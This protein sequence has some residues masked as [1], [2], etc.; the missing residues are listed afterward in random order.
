MVLDINQSKEY[1][2]LREKVRERLFC[3]M[4]PQQFKVVERGSGPVLCLA[5]AGSGKTTAMVNRILHLYLFGPQF[6]PQPTI[7]N[8]IIPEDVD[9]LREWVEE[10][11]QGKV[12]ELSPRVLELVRSE[13]IPARSILAI[14]FTNKAA[15][16]MQTRL[17]NLLGGTL[18]DMWV[19]TFHAACV[20]ILHR[21]I[22]ALDYTG[23]FSI[24]DAQDQEQ[25]IK[26]VLK[27]M[28]LDDKKFPP[29]AIRT[30]ISKF[31]SELKGVR[32]AA[33]GARDY[34]EEKGAQAYELYQKQLKENN[35][36]DFDDLIMLT[37]KLFRTNP[38]I[39]QKYQERF[40]YIMVDEYQDTN[41][42]QYVLVNLL[43]DAHHNLCVVGDDDQS[44]YGF[45]QADIRNILDFERDNPD[46][47]VIKLE[48]NYRSTC[49]ILA[50]ANE[51]IKNNMGRKDKTLW[52]QNPE[53]ELIV[54]YRAY[55]E[56]DE[57]RFVADR[58]RELV[59]KGST[60]QECAVLMRTNAQSRALE[61]EFMRSG[62]PYRIYGGLRFYDRK[63]IK[64][65]LAY[66]KL[67]VNPSD[68][69]S[70]RRIINVPR[71]GIGEATL[72]KIAEYSSQNGLS[73][74]GGLGYHKELSVVGKAGRGIESFVQL[75]DKLKEDV[76]DPTVTKITERI[77]METGYWDELN[78]ENTM[79][80]QSRMENLKEFMTVTQ[81]YDN[82]AEGPSLSDFLS[83]IS[84]VTD[85]D[86]FEDET[87]AVVVMTMHMA[88]GLEFNNV[89]LVG[90][91]E[92]IFPHS[93]SLLDEKEVEEERRLCYVALTRARERLF[94]I[95]AKERTIYGRR[96]NNKSS[97]F[98]GE[99]PAEFREEYQTGSD[100]F[101][102]TPADYQATGRR[103]TGYI[104]SN[105]DYTIGDKVEHKKWG[106]GVVVSIRGQG[107]E[108]ELKI[109]FPSEGIKTL[110]AR[111]APLQKIK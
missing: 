92:G 41:H 63:E 104:P 33:K 72:L 11:S 106:Q 44:I 25:I 111:Y 98:M 83:R 35:A 39:L 50:A 12:E 26:R 10:N 108:A 66:L 79:E 107:G 62:I 57:A 28:D 76:K 80:S 89:F 1:W 17:A 48:Q 54:Q 13:G 16:E 9:L 36:L 38:E 58:V 32:E 2:S 5:G 91:E 8:D 46:S 77:I 55:T 96:S 74:Y 7:P 97:R 99:I 95:N 88:K 29:R 52:T 110:L 15:Q 87:K 61:E 70:L 30:V 101:K 22:K 19:M 105:L 69:V 14:T 31:K 42:A 84:L 85:L 27:E 40:H 45:R 94:M 93:R 37:V 60:Y 109:A 6:N 64:D 100:F 34:F 102:T 53:G 56:K 78:Q 81:E 49:C 3:H 86:S 73:L 21:E 75:M 47:V 103:D 67:L 71:R 18:K 82:G 20:R 59:D 24:Y 68:E 4:N 51:V 43:A 65:I 23:D 90:L